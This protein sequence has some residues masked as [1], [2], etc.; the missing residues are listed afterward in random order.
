[1]KT[2]IVVNRNGMGEAHSDLSQK[3]IT[4]YFSIMLEEMAIPAY[5]CFY[6]EGVKLTIDG[7]PILEYLKELEK[8]GV[9]IL[10]CKTCLV[11][12]DAV[13]RVKAGCVATMYDIMGAQNNCDKVI[14]L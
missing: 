11:Y 4:N 2:T 12:Y 3:L 14:V 13:D 9:N 10:I 7:S 5:L 1:M 6:A 8:R